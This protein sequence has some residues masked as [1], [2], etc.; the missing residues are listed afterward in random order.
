MV[1]TVK[2]NKFFSEFELKAISMNMKS[3]TCVFNIADEYLQ[4]DFN[5]FFF[6]ITFDKL[7]RVQIVFVK[8]CDENFNYKSISSSNC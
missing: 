4:L 6:N 3:Q 1:S 7:V 8:F 2:K 5:H